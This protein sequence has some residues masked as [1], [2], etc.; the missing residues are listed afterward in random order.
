MKSVCMVFKPNRY[1]NCFLPVYLGGESIQYVD[2]VKYLGVLLRSDSLDNND[3]IRQTRGLYGRS[4][5]LLRK[6]ARC[7]KEVKIHLFQS[8]CTSM[9]CAQL[10][11]NYSQKVFQKLK[12]AYNN[13]FRFLFKYDRQCSAK[14]MLVSHNVPYFDCLIRKSIYDFKCRIS[15]SSNLLVSTLRNNF[16]VQSGGMYTIW[17]NNLYKSA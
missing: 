3:I 6:F 2:S 14:T 8:Y 16:V 13:A 1:R 11:S 7:S 17:H 12:V 10:W 9:Y 15:E 5:I 4:N